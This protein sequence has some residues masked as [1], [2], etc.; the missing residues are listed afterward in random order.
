MLGGDEFVFIDHLL[1]AL[2]PLQAPTLGY[3]PHVGSK[4]TFRLLNRAWYRKYVIAAAKQ[5]GLPN[6]WRQNNR[7][8]VLSLIPPPPLPT[9]LSLQPYLASVTLADTFVASIRPW[10]NNMPRFMYQVGPLQHITAE[11][12]EE[13]E[14]A[15]MGRRRR[16]AEHDQDDIRPLNDRVCTSRLR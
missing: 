11:D 10:Q 16:L 13:D 7:A 2:S 15:E 1:L 12:S 8:K 9:Y 6:P 14:Q 5:L 3:R 4:T